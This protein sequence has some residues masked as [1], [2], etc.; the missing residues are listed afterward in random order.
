M[1]SRSLWLWLI[2]SVLGLAMVT[3]CTREKPLVT[4]TPTATVAQVLATPSPTPTST[5]TPVAPEP[6]YYSV[7]PGDT[8]WAIANQFGVS[9]L[10]LVSANGLSDADSLQPGQRL[11]IPSGG[12]EGVGEGAATEMAAEPQSD[13]GRRRTHLVT[14]G[15]TLWS[16]ALEYGTSVWQIATLNELDPEAI[17]SLGQQ[18][19][20]P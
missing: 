19:M 10:D 1:V 18:L 14:E 9:L 20:I 4:P 2:V 12:E 3:G 5:A 17:L 16:I 15:D 8:A 7:R 13:P 11:L 6:T